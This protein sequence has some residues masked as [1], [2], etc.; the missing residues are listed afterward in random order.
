[1]THSG[2]SFL[3]SHMLVQSDNKTLTSYMWKQS[4][5]KFLEMLN[6]FYQLL[7]L[8][9][10]LNVELHPMY[11]AGRYNGVADHLSIKRNMRLTPPQGMLPPAD[12]NGSNL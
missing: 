2:Q 8:L 9:D 12:S 4:I 7:E 10:I 6:L 11:L 3:G 5:T 1:M